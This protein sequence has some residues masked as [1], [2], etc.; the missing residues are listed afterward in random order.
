M[1]TNTRAQDDLLPTYQLHLFSTPNV[2]Q[3]SGLWTQGTTQAFY[4]N[5]QFYNIHKTVLNNVQYAI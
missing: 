1:I 3:H 4:H 2:S 5:H